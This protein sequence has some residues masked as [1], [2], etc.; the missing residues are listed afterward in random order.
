MTDLTC[1]TVS[2]IPG[3]NHRERLL[4]AELFPDSKDL[5]TLSSGDISRITG[6]K[7]KSEKF[8]MRALLEEAERILEYTEKNGI[9]TVW[10]WDPEY[11]PQLREIFDPPVLL[12]LKGMPLDN[13]VFHTAVVGTRYPT[14]TGRSNA[15]ILG[16]AL[17]EKG[18]PVVSGLALGIDS[19]VHRGVLE[20]KG[21]TVG[22]LGNGI[23]TVYPRSNKKLAFEIVAN[24]GALLSEYPPGIP[25]LKY[26]FPKRN[27]IISGLCRSVVI[28]EAPVKSGALI[29]AEFALEQGRDLFVH[30]GSLS[31]PRGTGGLKLSLDG[32][33]IIETPDDML[34]MA[35]AG[36]GGS[37]RIL[38][39]PEVYTLSQLLSMELDG[40]LVQ[41]GGTQYVRGDML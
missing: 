38:D 26:N 15:Y 33:G 12:Y 4:I 5:L 22:V 6:R 30:G 17:A 39:D 40:A 24:G 41:Y 20:V 7:L 2:R 32:A 10:F 37:L 35:E 34:R 14:R 8:H 9:K 1:I 11:P 29:T 23:D 18:I 36:I 16:A 25:P 31:S 27:R 19:A 28:V 3:L 21:K 13:N